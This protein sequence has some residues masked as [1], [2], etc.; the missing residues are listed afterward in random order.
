MS[1]VHPQEGRGDGRGGGLSYRE[2]R[3]SGVG[4]KPE[5]RPP[6]EVSKA[7]IMTRGSACEAQG[8][9]Q[10]GVEERRGGEGGTSR[11][12]RLPASE[13]GEE[14]AERQVGPCPHR[15]LASDRGA[16]WP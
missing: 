13:E 10:E 3:G 11:D 9:G 7:P 1:G 15:Q 16:G 12:G 6:T 5:D 14:A 8:R 2:K 4:W